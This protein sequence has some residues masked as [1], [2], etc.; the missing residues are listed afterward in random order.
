MKR[1]AA[2]GIAPGRGA[3][4]RL[5]IAVPAFLIAA[6]ALPACGPS[7]P[8]P[9][10]GSD[11]TATSSGPRPHVLLVVIDC[12]G[13][14]HLGTYGYER[15][16]SPNLDAL[17]SEGIVFERAIVQSNWTK[18]SMASML[19]GTHVSQHRVTEGHIRERRE[20]GSSA[21]MSHVLSPDLQTLAELLAQAGYRT[22][23][24]VNQGHLT[25]YMGFDQG[26]D[27]YR[28]DLSDPEVEL[29]FA[30]WLTTA[31]GGPF[32]A[33]L[34]LLD[35]HFPYDPPDH[36][37]RFADSIEPRV[38]KPA[39]RQGGARE[40]IEDDALTEENVRELRAL[41]D[42]E[43]LVVDDRVRRIL[44]ILRS[45][46]LYED[47]LVVVTADHGEA[48]L[49]HGLFEHGGS[50][51]YEEV[52]RVPWIM[53]LPGGERAGRRVDSVVQVAD[54]L[55]TV[56]DYLGLPPPAG[57]AGRS[58]WPRVLGD[59]VG[60]GFALAETSDLDGPRAAY[61]GDLKVIFDGNLE[62]LEVYD[63]HED[64]RETDNLV[65]TVD[66][67]R[68]AEVR[69]AVETRLEANARFAA[70]IRR[71]EVTLGA[72]QVEKLRAL[73]YVQ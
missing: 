46:E 72:E 30:A 47:T 28:H 53:R 59:D 8:S 60:D 33:F 1:S 61:L 67:D 14:D 24:F 17:A 6:L 48:L 71:G 70:G 11:D 22:A 35:L 52:L 19:T 4:S 49:E 42:G 73:G 36:V 65:G 15:P 63:L 37:D 50:I 16:T 58:A 54:I 40:L 32:F 57:I 66:P 13:A 41:Y 45:N 2:S 5:L 38:L 51:L 26:F 29:R 27:V 12:L 56:L 34:H 31:R 18:P 62:A 9:D 43:V 20:D 3:R 21:L 44:Q 25:D 10:A 68:V 64:P 55:P 69:R 39:M 7:E 23:G